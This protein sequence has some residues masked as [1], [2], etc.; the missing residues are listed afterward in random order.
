MTIAEFESYCKALGWALEDYP[1]IT[2]RDIGDL[3]D[4]ERRDLWIIRNKNLKR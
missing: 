4:M 2:A 3:F 1:D